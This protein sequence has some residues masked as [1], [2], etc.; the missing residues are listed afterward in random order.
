MS[1]NEQSPSSDERR[2]VELIRELPPTSLSAERRA[3]IGARLVA[4]AAAASTVHRA[5]SARGAVPIRVVAAFA[6]VFVAAAAI[7]VIW[8]H[9]GAGASAAHP[10]FRA[11]VHGLN[12]AR[13]VRSGPQ[14]DEVVRLFDGVVAVEVSPLQVGERFRVVV[15]DGEVE[16]RGTAFEVR[17]TNDHLVMVR[18]THGRVE[19]HDAE[20]RVSV[21][22]AGD[23][24]SPRVGSTRSG[25]AESS[26]APLPTLP[27]TVAPV[28]SPAAKPLVALSTSSA[29][30]VASADSRASPRLESRGGSNA[31]PLAPVARPEEVAFQEGVSLLRAGDAA[32][33]ASAFAI[34]PASDALAEDARF[35][36]AIALA[37]SGGASGAKALQSFLDTFPAS[38]HRGEAAVALGWLLVASGDPA[39]AERAFR[40]GLGS[41]DE[42]VRASGEEGLRRLDV[43]L[44]RP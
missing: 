44:A 28:A 23:S 1:L 34:V 40:V 29:A 43:P 21:L 31:P 12:G 18:V 37:R 39:G 15:G 3:A 41:S 42:R 16:V 6:A 36:G 26:S 2:V 33:A 4:S 7:L 10:L 38:P 27:P 8:M 24:W 19:V 32:G 17:A 30:I 35:F 13:F 5:A 20:N 22:T 25:T 9:V 14:P 11:S